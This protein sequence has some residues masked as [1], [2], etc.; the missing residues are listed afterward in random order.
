MQ[1]SV[2]IT[3]LE[4]CV[5]LSQCKGGD[6]RKTIQAAVE[7]Q[8]PPGSRTPFCRSTESEGEAASTGLE[9]SLS[10]TQQ[11]TRAP[12]NYFL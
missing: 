8:E 11:E 12:G 10:G 3:E 2:L 4:V 7:V 9:L 5:Y 6:L 1:L